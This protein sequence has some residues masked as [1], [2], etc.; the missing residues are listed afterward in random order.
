LTCLLLQLGKDL[1]VDR[2]IWK[3]TIMNN[4]PLGK[5][6]LAMLPLRPTLPTCESQPPP[7]G[8]PRVQGAITFRVGSRHMSATSSP[9]LLCSARFKGRELLGGG[10]ILAWHFNPMLTVKLSLGMVVGGPVCTGR[11]SSSHSEHL[12]ISAL[13]FCLEE[14]T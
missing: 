3:G 6:F 11:L 12:D 14:A 1:A 13:A 7:G 5:A 4:R 2:S 10:E 8:S 9:C